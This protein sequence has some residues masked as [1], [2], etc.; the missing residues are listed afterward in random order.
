LNRAAAAALTISLLVAGCGNDD[1]T[2]SD[3]PTNAVDASEDESTDTNDGETAGDGTE[4]DGEPDA[5]AGAENAASDAGEPSGDE[6]DDETTGDGSESGAD[7]DPTTMT[8]A[9]EGLAAFLDENRPETEE[10]M[11]TT[12]EGCPLIDTATL[13]AA[14]ES[15][16]GDPIGDEM[17]TQISWLGPAQFQVGCGVG[18]DDPAGD[19]PLVAVAAGDVGSEVTLD[20]LAAESIQ[21]LTVENDRAVGCDPDGSIC[22]ALSMIDGLAVTTVVNGPQ[23]TEE[24]TL[25]LLD[26][27]QQAVVDSLSAG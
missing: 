24:T 19:A 22:M 21:E 10:E 6:T 17:E 15:V 3:D 18:L 26:D 27:L 13:S 11:T 12:L 16:G 1:E 5:D 4:S 20:G 25:A 9:R 7:I 8:A 14:Q 2:T 23:A